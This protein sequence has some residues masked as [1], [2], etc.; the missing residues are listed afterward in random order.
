[1]CITF[2]QTPCG[3]LVIDVD[4]EEDSFN[5]RLKMVQQNYN[6]QY[7]VEIFENRVPRRLPPFSISNNA[8]PATPS[9]TIP[10]SSSPASPPS[11]SP[12]PA[13]QRTTRPSPA[14][15]SPARPRPSRVILDE[16]STEELTSLQADWQA[17]RQTDLHMDWQM[18]GN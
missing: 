3:L 7:L 16:K 15:P 4:Y 18:F 2:F 6:G 5:E 11:A 17:D 8:T 12:S 13:R 9:T 10:A 1:M 14:R